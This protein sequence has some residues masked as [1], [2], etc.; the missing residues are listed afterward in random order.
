MTHIDSGDVT[1]PVL[2]MVVIPATVLRLIPEPAAKLPLILPVMVDAVMVEIFAVL[3][4]SVIT[5]PVNILATQAL[6]VLMFVVEQ[7]SVLML[8]FGETLRVDMDA[9]PPQVKIDNAVM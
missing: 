5:L 6:L 9:V 1:S 7:F 4:F 3:V 2:V 8:Q